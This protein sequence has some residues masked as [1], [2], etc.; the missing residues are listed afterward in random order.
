MK[1]ALR[2]AIGTWKVQ[3]NMEVDEA[4][5]EEV[6][7]DIDSVRH[8]NQFGTPDTPLMEVAC[9]ND[10]KDTVIQFFKDSKIEVWP[11]NISPLLAPDI[12][13]RDNSQLATKRH[14]GHCIRVLNAWWK[15]AHYVQNSDTAAYYMKL[16]T[17][18]VRNSGALY[19]W[20]QCI[21]GI[22]IDARGV[23][24]PKD[25]PKIDFEYAQ[26]FEATEKKKKQQTEG[27]RSKVICHRGVASAKQ[28]G[29]A[30]TFRRP[31]CIVSKEGNGG[32]QPRRRT[33]HVIRRQND[34][35]AQ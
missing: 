12:D 2:I 29:E 31:G 8:L 33:D 26:G 14:Y 1:R 23:H 9:T 6:T 20:P 13:P 24:N 25:N 32:R 34:T 30:S 5:G 3:N 35:S 17:L 11:D 10:H 28:G 21:V 18:A 15:A 7:P 16:T 4:A 22:S 27:S 19:T